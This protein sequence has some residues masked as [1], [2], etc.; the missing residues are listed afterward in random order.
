MDMYGTARTNYFKVKD[1][2]KFTKGCYRREAKIL[3]SDSHPGC[4]AVYS[5]NEYGMWSNRHGMID[6]I[7]KNLADKEV[8]VMQEIG[9]EGLRFMWGI[10]F[11]FDN[12]GNIVTIDTQD[13]YQLAKQ[14]FGI[15]VNE[16]SY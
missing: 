15:D 6:F 2:Q 14:K 1:L 8:C 12:T 3:K 16:A 10:S 9:N 13:I 11:A 5:T 4:V 7:T